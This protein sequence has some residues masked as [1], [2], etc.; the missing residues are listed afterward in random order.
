MKRFLT[1]LFMN[2]PF[3]LKS[4]SY[5][6][7]SSSIVLQSNYRIRSKKTSKENIVPTLFAS[8]NDDAETIPLNCIE[9]NPVISSTDKNASIYPPVVV[10]H[11]ICGS[12]R[13]FKTWGSA[14]A[15]S[16]DLPRTIYLLDL[17]NHGESLPHKSSMAYPDVAADVI[18]FLDDRGIDQ[19]VVMGHCWGGKVGA[20]TALLYPDRVSGVVILETSPVSYAGDRLWTYRTR[21]MHNLNN[22][23]TSQIENSENAEHLLGQHLPLPWFRAYVKR[24]LVQSAPLK[25]EWKINLPAIASEMGAMGS[26]GIGPNGESPKELGCSY[27]GPVLFIAGGRSE[28]IKSSHLQEISQMFPNYLIRTL[29]GAGHFV[30]TD[31]PKDSLKNVKMY[32]DNLPTLIQGK[33]KSPSTTNE[34]QEQ[35]TEQHTQVVHD[36]IDADTYLYQPLQNP[37]QMHHQIDIYG[38]EFHDTL[39]SGESHEGD[40]YGK[41]NYTLADYYGCDLS[42]F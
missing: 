32:L 39:D 3:L 13:T 36:S 9:I 37:V 30:M 14:L 42:G 24:N 40:H 16:L 26:F 4:L 11:A 28:F 21:L 12:A 10:L 31:A 41:Y 6:F 1:I 25:W 8:F 33:S 2:I 20:A 5:A 17:R 18:R 38:S 35:E 7:D 19:A 34:K 22:I 27:G 23:D 15:R 29:H